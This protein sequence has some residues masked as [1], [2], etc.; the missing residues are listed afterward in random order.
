MT[1]TN[2]RYAT[3]RRS[4]AGKEAI[5]RYESSE[6]AKE[7]RRRYNQSAKGIATYVRRRKDTRKQTRAVIDA[8]KNRPCADCGGTFDPVCMD[9]HHVQKKLFN[10]GWGKHRYDKVER[11]IAK[12]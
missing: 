12:C 11:E 3:Y 5:R 4:E 10:I 1:Y 2:E 6:A 7:R 8:A 9:F